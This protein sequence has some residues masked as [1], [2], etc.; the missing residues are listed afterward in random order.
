MSKILVER[1]VS[2]GEWNPDTGTTTDV[3]ELVYQGPA[4]VQKVARPSKRD[5]T[6]DQANFQTYR[7]QID[8]VS[9]SHADWKVNDR[10]TVLENKTDIN[11]VGEVMY[12]WGDGSSSHSIWSNLTCQNN[13]RQGI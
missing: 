8:F 4:R 13:M 10:I 3:I 11:L 1:V 7:V 6:E 2:R 12:V 9:S 5:F